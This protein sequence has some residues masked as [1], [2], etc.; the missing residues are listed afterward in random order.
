MRSTDGRIDRWMMGSRPAMHSRSAFSLVILPLGYPI[1][2]FPL[3]RAS[4]DALCAAFLLVS[5]FSPTHGARRGPVHPPH[6]PKS[7]SGL[8]YSSKAI[9][10][11][12]DAYVW[13]TIGA[14]TSH[15]CTRTRRGR[16]AD[17]ICTRPWCENIVNFTKTCRAG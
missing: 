5:R 13:L 2:S 12:Y 9:T 7:S 1:A 4:T 17:A 3:P 14:R 15:S 10:H 16:G 6:S 11:T 8:A